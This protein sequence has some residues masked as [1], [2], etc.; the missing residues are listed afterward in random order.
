MLQTIVRY[1]IPL[2][3]FRQWWWTGYRRSG[4]SISVSTEWSSEGLCRVC[5]GSF[6]D[7]QVTD[8]VG[9]RAPSVGI[10]KGFV[11]FVTQFIC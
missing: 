10:Y 6:A 2:L 3:L 5:L 11:F 8:I 1:V 4:T 9:S 7:E